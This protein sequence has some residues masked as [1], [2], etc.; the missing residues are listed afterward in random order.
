MSSFAKPS[1]T[2]PQEAHHDGPWTEACLAFPS[3]DALKKG[4]EIYVVADAGGGTSVAAH[5]MAL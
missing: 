3:L 5:E 1:R 2:R 4:Y